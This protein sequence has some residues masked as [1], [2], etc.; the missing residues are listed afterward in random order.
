M[1]CSIEEARIEIKRER[2]ESPESLFVAQEN[3]PLT[4][5]SSGPYAGLK[6]AK[7]RVR[8]HENVESEDDE[9]KPAVGPAQNVVKEGDVGEDVD[10]EMESEKESEKEAETGS[11]PV[12]GPGKK[13]KKG[14]VLKDV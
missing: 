8:V 2:E 9:M 7:K 10:W 4:V 5:L 1:F 14:G 3:K 6:S 12:F 11:K 13:V